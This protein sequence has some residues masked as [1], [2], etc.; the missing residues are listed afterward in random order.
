VDWHW[1]STATIATLFLFASFAGFAGCTMG[2][3]PTPARPASAGTAPPI[4][5]TPVTGNPAVIQ[6]P[7]GPIWDAIPPE[8][9]VF[10][11][12]QPVEIDD[13]VSAALDHPAQAASPDDIANAYVSELTIGGWRTVVN[14]PIED[15]S[16]AVDA[17]RDG[18]TCRA[19]VRATPLGGIVRI[20]ILYGADCPSPRS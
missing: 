11:G 5:P 10:A 2:P 17:V 20:T 6:S 14:G 9:L 4:E 3:T 1:R 7:W 13:P 15:G 16:I 12:A 8:L 19:Q 18:T